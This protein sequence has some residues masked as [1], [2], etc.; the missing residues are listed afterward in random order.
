VPRFAEKHKAN[1]KAPVPAH[2]RREPEEDLTVLDAPGPLSP[3][4]HERL[5]EA[6]RRA[7]EGGAR[8]GRF[9][10]D[11]RLIVSYSDD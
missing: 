2:D 7:P 9:G 4:E 5:A 11:T 8:G 6:G 10:I 1:R 3:D